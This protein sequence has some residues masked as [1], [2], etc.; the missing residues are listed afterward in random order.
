MAKNKIT[1][2]NE[3]IIKL[4]D[5]LEIQAPTLKS[6]FDIFKI[7]IFPKNSSREGEIMDYREANRQYMISNKG[8][9]L[10]FEIYKQTI[11]DLLDNKKGFYQQTYI[12]NVYKNA[13]STA[14][15]T[16]STLFEH[17]Y[18]SEYEYDKFT[19]MSRINKIKFMQEMGKMMTDRDTRERYSSEQ[20]IEALLDKYNL[21]DEG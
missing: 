5:E 4:R 2:L 19:N 9:Q 12:R 17:G 15:A 7:V 14:D 1:A 3:R 16:A 8:E 21:L 20:I 6:E 18:F 13:S 10:P 11:S